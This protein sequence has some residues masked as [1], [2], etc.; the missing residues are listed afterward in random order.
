MNSNITITIS[1][2]ELTA[3]SETEKIVNESKPKSAGSGEDSTN[4]I[5]RTALVQAGKQ[6]LQY[7]TS[8]Y[9]NLTGNAIGQRKINNMIELASIGTTLA[10][11]GVVVGGIAVATQMALKI[12]NNSIEN[13]RSNQVADLIYQRSGNITRN[14]GRGTNE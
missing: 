13:A 9:G 5:V 14:G 10:V 4:Q 8:Q 2:S 1:K 12:A 6:A 7:A 11:G 3:P